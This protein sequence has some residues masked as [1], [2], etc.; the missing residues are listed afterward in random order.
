VSDSDSKSGNPRRRSA[1]TR[2]IAMA[3]SLAVTAAGILHAA[4]AHAGEYAATA[5][6][7]EASDSR[8]GAPSGADHSCNSCAVADACHFWMTATQPQGRPSVDWIATVAPTGVAPG[9]ATVWAR[10]RP[11][12]SLV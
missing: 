7:V 4:H 8:D 5:V 6:H 12:K 10:A 1:F 2:V 3:L 9:D 11:P